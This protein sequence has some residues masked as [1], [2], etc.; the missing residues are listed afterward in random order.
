MKGIALLIGAPP[1][2]KKV[3]YKQYN[4]ER[5]Y[6]NKLLIVPKDK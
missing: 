5:S 4:K 1:N 6:H 2:N 3:I